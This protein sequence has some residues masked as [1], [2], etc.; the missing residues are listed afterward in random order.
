M[1]GTLIPGD[2]QRYKPLRQR[3]RQTTTG[4]CHGSITKGRLF[5]LKI[6]KVLTSGLYRGLRI[7]DLDFIPENA[8]TSCNPS[9]FPFE[10]VILPN[11]EQILQ[12]M[13]TY[14]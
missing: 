6:E 1:E 13:Y 9:A 5:I 10:N 8:I 3:D 7:E 12:R 4:C 11:F 14:V 2:G